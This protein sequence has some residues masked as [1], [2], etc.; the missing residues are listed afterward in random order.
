MLTPVCGLDVPCCPTEVKS[1]VKD[2]HFSSKAYGQRDS[3]ETKMD[4]RLQL[5]ILQ[6]RAALKREF[7]N[8]WEKRFLE[9]ELERDQY[10]EE[11]RAKSE[12]D[13]YILWQR[14]SVMIRDRL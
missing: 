5:D 11:H 13:K 12:A 7:Q 14:V 2:T 9:A 4:G 3:K 10:C 1:E 6:S 8:M